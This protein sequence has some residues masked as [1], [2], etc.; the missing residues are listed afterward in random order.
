[1]PVVN[2]PLNPKG[3]PIAKIFCPTFT[4][5]ESPN[6]IEGNFLLASIFNKAKSFSNPFVYK[7]ND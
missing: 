4:K 3:F 6:S 2:V 5:E 1:M 7:T